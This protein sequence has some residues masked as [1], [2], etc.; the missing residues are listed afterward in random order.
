MRITER[1]LRQIIRE[2]ARRVGGSRGRRLGENS[3]PSYSFKSE[4]QVR[5]DA[6]SMD[7]LGLGGHATDMLQSHL[8]KP[9]STDIAR[10]SVTED[11][12]WKEWWTGVSVERDDIV[13]DAQ[14]GPLHLVRIYGG[15]AA[16][17]HMKKRG[18]I[19]YIDVHSLQVVIR[20]DRELADALREW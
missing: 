9:L 20:D 14:G 3:R 12:P 8:G 5:S 4:R 19:L 13:K 2:E 16:G 6:V 10:I 7:R 15:I 11:M 17:L 18:P 1:R